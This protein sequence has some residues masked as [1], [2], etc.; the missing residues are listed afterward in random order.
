MLSRPGDAFGRRRR[1]ESERQVH[2]YSPDAQ[3]P[4][5]GTDRRPGGGPGGRGLGEHQAERAAGGGTVLHGEQPRTRR[6]EQQV[7]VVADHAPALGSAVRQ[8]LERPR[9]DS[10]RL[11]RQARLNSQGRHRRVSSVSA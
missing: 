6:Q 5:V 11:E 10:V 3:Q 8:C 2:R 9:T 1:V 4:G 7:A